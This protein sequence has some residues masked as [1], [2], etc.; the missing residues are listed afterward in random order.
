MK[1]ST[2]ELIDQ[3]SSTQVDARSAA[4]GSS[5]TTG[6][7]LTVARPEQS[8]IYEMY[9]ITPAVSFTPTMMQVLSLHGSGGALPPYDG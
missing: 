5:Y 4:A 6:W 3:T 1:Y 9:P 7:D 8:N 2:H